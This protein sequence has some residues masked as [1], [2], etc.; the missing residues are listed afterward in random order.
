MKSKLMVWA[1]VGVTAAVAWAQTAGP[2]GSYEGAL[3]GTNVYV[4]SQPG[5]VGAYPCTK[6]SVPA[7]VTVVGRDGDWLK[8]QAP[9]G[10]FS[11]ISKQYVTLDATTNVGTVTADNVYVRAGG[12]LREANFFTPQTRLQRAETVQVI[13]QVGDMYKIKCPKKAYFWISARYVKPVGAAGTGTGTVS[14]RVATQPATAPAV[15]TGTGTST[16]AKTGRHVPPSLAELHAIE[17]LLVAEYQNSVEQRDFAP[18]LAKYRAVDVSG[19]NEFLKPYV[20]SRIAL[21]EHAM[22]RKADAQA[23]QVLINTVTKREEALRSQHAKVMANLPSTRPITAYAAQGVLRASELF[24]GGT[25][26]PRRF[27]IR[28]RHTFFINAYVQCTTNSVPLANYIGKYIGVKGTTKFDENLGLDVVEAKSVRVLS[29]STSFP[30]PPEP[31]IRPLPPR[32]TTRP[33]GPPGQV[34]PPTPTPTPSPTPTRPRS[35]GW[36]PI[37]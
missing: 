23:V 15:R 20:D 22:K 18:L 13:G 4:R 28:D 35:A 1:C 14:V 8:I 31:R 3:T 33:A 32:P 9:A 16:A 27:L 26:A 6:L 37:C 25:A 34:L 36:S 2:A 7:K 19:D 24:P 5:G 30:M 10:C 11:V 29:E 17:K 12:E 21:V